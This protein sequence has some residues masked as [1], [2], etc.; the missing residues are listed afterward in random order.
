MKKQKHKV[1][2]TPEDQRYRCSQ[3]TTHL[4]CPHLARIIRP[5]SQTFC[6]ARE[7]I[8][9][10]GRGCKPQMSSLLVSLIYTVFRELQ[11]YLY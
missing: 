6:G 11:I 3:R 10:L 4:T 7:T 8:N 9:S 1:E 5:G 2:L